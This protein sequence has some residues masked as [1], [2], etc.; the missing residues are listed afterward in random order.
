[1]PPERLWNNE[2]GAMLQ[3]A[4]KCEYPQDCESS[5]SCGA[6]RKMRETQ[7]KK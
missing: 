4:L 6:I 7:E 3:A 2:H 1:M 5:V